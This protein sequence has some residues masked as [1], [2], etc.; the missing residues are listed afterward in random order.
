MNVSYRIGGALTGTIFLF[1]LCAPT[2][3]LG[4]TLNI[5][6][7]E[8]SSSKARYVKVCGATE[9]AGPICSTLT[10]VGTS[11]I[12]NTAYEGV[13]SPELLVIEGNCSAQFWA[14]DHGDEAPA[15]TLSAS[16]GS[17]R[18]DLGFLPRS[19]RFECLEEATVEA[20]SFPKQK[21][22]ED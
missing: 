5:S 8:N 19:Y 21:N 22:T 11:D 3:A 7:G 4:E 18:E 2:F 1:S 10:G 17:I 20:N 16:V 15:A 13:V 12:F 6:K 14:G 9:Q